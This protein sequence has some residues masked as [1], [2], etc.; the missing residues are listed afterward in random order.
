[1]KKGI[2]LVLIGL[3]IF[4]VFLYFLSGTAGLANIATTLERTNLF[5]YSLAFIC[6]L[7]GVLLFSLTWHSLLKL[8][9][10]R[11]SFRK[12]ILYILVGTFVDLLIPAESISGDLSRVY[13]M[14]K[15]TIE[16]TGK[17]VASIVSHRII[18]MTTT[19]VG[20]IVSST[21]FLLR[22][23][24]SE[25]VV[26]IIAIVSVGTAISIIALCYLSA[27]PQT[28]EKVIDRII[29]FVAFVSRGHWQLTSLRAKVQ[30]ML[31]AFHQGIEALSTRPKSLAWPVTFTV[32]SW[33]FDLL[34]PFFVF[35]SLGFGVPLS[36]IVVVYSISVALQTIPLGIPGEI[37]LIEIVMTSLYTLLGIPI[38]VSAAA[39][40]L[41]RLVTFWFK[42]FVGYA[43]MQWVGIKT[44]IGPR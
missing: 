12:T 38:A 34:I 30:K 17:V 4:I 16:D 28:T 41:V 8:L 37:G 14:H 3:L 43:A 25:L 20:L 11:I 2:P 35:V 18:S 23:R 40:V 39:T 29:R 15:N 32:A 33:F 44:L 24:P 6:T 13:L 10:I 19:L 1:M 31:T 21:Y 7:L 5:Y 26:N 22:Y 42:L 9:S 27:R 36:L